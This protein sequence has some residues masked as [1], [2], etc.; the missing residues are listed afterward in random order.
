MTVWRDVWIAAMTGAVT[1]LG[2]FLVMTTLILT[3][4]E[5]GQGG[6]AVSGLIIAESLPVVLLAA[7][8][9]RIADRFDSR[10]I[11]LVAGALQIG[12]CLALAG[13]HGLGPRILL[14]TLL[15]CG[16]AVVQPT[17][18]ALLLTMVTREDLPKASGLTQTASQ[19]G[20]IAGPALAGFAQG[21]LG[22][23]ATLRWAAVAFAGTVVAGLLYRTRR[24]GAARTPEHVAA[25]TDKVRLDSLLRVMTVGFAV[26]VGAVAAVNVVDVFFVKS[27]LGAS[28]GAYG[29]I[30][31]MWTVGMIG[32]TWITARLLGRAKDDGAIVIWSFVCLA[33]TSA[34]V[35]LGSTMTTIAPVVAI[36]LAGGVLNGAENTQVFT[37][38]GRRAPEHARGRLSARMMGAVQGA[39]LLGYAVGGVA[40]EFW[41]PRTVL[42]GGG[43][44][45]VVAV[46]AVTPWIRAAVRRS[47]RPV[48]TAEAG[49][50]EPVTVTV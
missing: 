6:L 34:L 40:L 46:I 39:A 32:G 8:T 22:P 4:Q 49:T 13:V 7:V 9:G 50:L 37:V 26:V 38:F 11:L 30:T 25:A 15:C 24:G 33:A 3:M 43:V 36:W 10:L 21:A 14:L 23:Q 28:S 1:G 29:L 16:T 48:A 41:S 42:A 18:Q 12:A 27:T 2:T 44:A 47:R 45:G 31:S 19:I 5:E 20:T 35:V 17:R